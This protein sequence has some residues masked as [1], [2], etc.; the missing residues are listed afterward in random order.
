MPY[1]KRNWCAHPRHL[2]TSSDGRNIFTKLGPKP[3]HPLGSRRIDPILAKF[4]NERYSNILNDVS[5]MLNESH[6]LCTKCYEEELVQ[7]QAAEH[8]RT[9]IEINDIM[10]DDGHNEADDK[11]DLKDKKYMEQVKRDYAIE[12]LNEVFK[13][14]QLEPLIP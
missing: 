7:Y 12:K 10:M 9:D 4:I 3:N 11:E 1:V 6:S 14:F 5:L 2:E 13:L 8:K